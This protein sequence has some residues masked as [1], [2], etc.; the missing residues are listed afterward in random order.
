MD[1]DGKSWNT[2]QR[3]WDQIAQNKVNDLL[4]SI[5]DASRAAGEAG[6]YTDQLGTLCGYID[7]IAAQYGVNAASQLL[8]RAEEVLQ[9]HADS[10]TFPQFEDSLTTA[11]LSK[12][13][14]VQVVQVTPRHNA[15]D[16]KAHW[17]DWIQ[18]LRQSLRS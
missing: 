14:Q 6:K 7:L 3:L 18:H 8:D 1:T 2:A 13:G 17:Q 5:E 15:I 16:A 12:N 9:E 11:K 4:S 10:I